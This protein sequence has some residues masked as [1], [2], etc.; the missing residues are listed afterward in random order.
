[1]RTTR[2][3]HTLVPNDVYN[4]VQDA[5]VALD[6]VPASIVTDALRRELARLVRRNGGPFPPRGKR[7]VKRGRPPMQRPAADKAEKAVAH[8]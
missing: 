5:A 3:L 6:R 1:M 7:R 8:R 4:G 2:Q